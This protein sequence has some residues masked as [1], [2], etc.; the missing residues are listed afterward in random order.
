MDKLRRFFSWLD[1]HRDWCFDLLRVYL[2]LGLLVKGVL[3]ASQPGLLATWME[4]G[5]R[6]RA[7][8]AMLD[9][10][11]ITAHL[12]GGLAMAFGL[13][14]R[15]AALAQIPILIGAVFFVHRDEGL[16]ARGQNLEFTLLVLFLLVLVF[17]HGSGRWSVDHYLFA[18]KREEP[19][20][21]KEHTTVVT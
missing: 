6:M 4:E 12:C 3:F 18:R 20:L 5:G 1:D 11:V 15:L 21:T 14:T 10:Y 8:P 13:L 17:A 9:H 2:G 19:S 16:F 7:T